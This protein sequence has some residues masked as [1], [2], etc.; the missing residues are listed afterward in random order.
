M[1][2]LMRWT[3]TVGR[4]PVPSVGRA[5]CKTFV[6]ADVLVLHIREG[7]RVPDLVVRQ[8]SEGVVLT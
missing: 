8:L 1:I 5:G 7:V 3:R 6:A 4:V 2:W